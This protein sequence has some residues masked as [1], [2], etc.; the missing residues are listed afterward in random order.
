MK[1][2]IIIPTYNSSELIEICLCNICNKLKN[3]DRYEILVIDGASKDSTITIVDRI[4]KQQKNISYISEKDKGIYDAMNRGIYLAKGDFLYFLGAD[5]KILFEMKDIENR[6]IDDN[7]VYYGNVILKDSNTKYDGVFNTNKIIEKNICHQAIFYP[8]KVL[9]NNLY[10]VH[11]KL[12]ADYELNIRLWKKYVFKH[13]DIYFA[14]YSN[15]GIST[16]MKD[17]EF[18][19]DFL[20]IIYTHL[21][22]KYVILKILNKIKKII[23]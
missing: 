7:V 18:R 5:D 10:N 16:Q 22:I 6:L 9:I 12:L 1:L 13:I 20:K 11:Y 19:K 14:I 4:A 21:G 23:R 15:D 17:I 2:S 3:S 8:R